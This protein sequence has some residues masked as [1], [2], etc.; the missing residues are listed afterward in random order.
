MWLPRGDYYHLHLRDGGG[1]RDGEKRRDPRSVL[2]VW[3]FVEC[4]D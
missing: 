2:E 3:H 1:S 4:V